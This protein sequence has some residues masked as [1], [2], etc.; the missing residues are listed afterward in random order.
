MFRR[1]TVVKH[2]GNQRPLRRERRLL[3]DEGG[4]SDHFPNG[5]VQLAGALLSPGSPDFLEASQQRRDQRRFPVG[6][7]EVVRVGEEV[8]LQVGGFG[9]QAPQKVGPPGQ[10]LQLLPLSKSLQDETAD[11]L[12][13][14]QS[15]GE[16]DAMVVNP[17]FSQ[18]LHHLGQADGV[19]EKV[20]PRLER[21]GTTPADIGH[22]DQVGPN[23]V[24]SLEHPA[25]ASHRCAEGNGQKPVFGRASQMGFYG[26]GFPP[27]GR[28]PS[29]CGQDQGRDQQAPDHPSDPG[30]TLS[31]RY[32]FRITAAENSSFFCRLRWGGIPSSRM[33]D[34]A[35][36]VDRRSSIHSIRTVP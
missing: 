18:Y 3:L 21:I 28:G 2:G 17:A 25:D 24:R 23:D 12:V 20:F 10:K 9:I 27:V 15:F 29:R 33:T 31:S 22:K 4:Q 1:R 11:D 26:A 34:S 5:E 19:L 6:T 16:G 35:S 32:H 7:R 30:S 13:H 14:G 8:A 36:L